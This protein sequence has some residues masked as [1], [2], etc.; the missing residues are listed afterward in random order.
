MAR[1]ASERAYMSGRRTTLAEDRQAY[2]RSLARA[3]KRA[4]ILGGALVLALVIL[5]AREFLQACCI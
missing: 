3:D 2:H 5:C 4:T 1:L